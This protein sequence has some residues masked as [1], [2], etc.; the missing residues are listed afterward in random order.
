MSRYGRFL[1]ALVQC[2]EADRADRSFA[3]VAES[4]SRTSGV[5]TLSDSNDRRKLVR[6]IRLDDEG[7]KKLLASLDARPPQ[8]N[9]PSE[10]R[11]SYR[12]KSQIAKIQQPGSAEAVSYQV[13]NRE[14]GA[15]GMSFLHGGFVHT[16]S[17]C[18]MQLITMHG[19]WVNAA[20]KVVRCE[21]LE[22]G[23]HDISIQF[24]RHIDPA[25]F[26]AEAIRSRVLLV[27][28][29]ELMLRMGK[30]YLEQLNA[31]VQTARDGQSA[32][33][34]AKKC[35]FDLILL[36]IVMPDMDGYA[37]VAE[38]RQAGYSGVIAAATGL[39]SGQDR[40]RCIDSGFDHYIPKPYKREDI[41]K[42]L[43]SLHDEP[44]NSSLE[45]DAAMTDAIVAFVAELPKQIR[46]LEAAAIASETEGLLAHLR[47]LKS[48]AG[49]FGFE[50][51]S[52]MAAEIENGV[53]AK[54]AI[55]E[56]VAEVK[57]LV[58]LCG[59]ARGPSQTPAKADQ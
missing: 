13:V 2:V 17:R 1:S 11:F 54:K 36:D 38:L 58:K 37:V 7:I 57:Q 30:I 55:V 51:I 6:T 28:D 47:T 14:I 29:E 10:T 42:I 12:T 39:T 44:L 22:G 5:T 21:Y 50:P 41:A 46:G 45:G 56:L 25:A 19:T 43:S 16:G 59:Q 9:K 35:V 23:V 31:E 20:G 32:L 4:G 52:Q 24:E 18:E 27:D 8:P 34:L 40:T 3:T 15:T 26:C 49:G 33:L 48:Q 53:L